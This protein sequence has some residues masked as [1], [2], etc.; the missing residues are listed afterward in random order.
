MVKQIVRL[1][2]SVCLFLYSLTYHSSLIEP[3]LYNFP[4]LTTIYFGLFNSITFFMCV[5]VRFVCRESLSIKKVTG[6]IERSF[7]GFNSLAFV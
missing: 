3:A 4:S 2:L 5:F 6:I 7:E 1:Q